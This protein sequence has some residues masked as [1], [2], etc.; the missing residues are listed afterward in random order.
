MSLR[1]AMMHDYFCIGKVTIDILYGWSGWIDK[2]LDFCDNFLP[3]VDDY[4]KLTTQN[5][6]F[7]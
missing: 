1:Y 7:L 5:P 2:C 6:T 3:K 4:E